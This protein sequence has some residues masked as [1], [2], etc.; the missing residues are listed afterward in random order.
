MALGYI[1]RLFQIESQLEN[2][3]PRLNTRGERDFA[4]IAAARQ[5][6]SKHILDEFKQWL[7]KEMM[8]GRILPKSEV[9]KAFTYT[10]NQW[11]ALNRYVAEGY[12]SMDNNLAERMVK[13][14]AIGRKNY[15]FVGNERA[16]RNE[17][18]FYSL[19]S[20]AKVNRVEPMAWLTEVFTQ[21]PYHRPS[22]AFKQATAGEPVTSAEL[23]YLLPE[24]WLEKHPNHVWTINEIR[25]QERVSKDKARM[26]KL[27]RRK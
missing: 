22:L 12:L 17:A 14:A 25:R 9:K 11:T 8:A 3:Y 5:K 16:G 19:V 6:H 13:Y 27:K 23:D 21:L 4:A 2:A 20:S 1:A 26:R 10:L 7:D 15:L 24:L 18:N